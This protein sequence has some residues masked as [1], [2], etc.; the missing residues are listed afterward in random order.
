MWLMARRILEQDEAAE[1]GASSP[2]SVAASDPDQT[3]A[4]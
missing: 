3:E 2:E 1:T 4:A